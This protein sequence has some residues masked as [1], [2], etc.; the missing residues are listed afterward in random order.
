MSRAWNS[1]MSDKEVSDLA[2][3]ERNM[4]VL[5][6]ANYTNKV[7]SDWLQYEKSRNEDISQE[8]RKGP[9]S[10]WYVDDREEMKGWSRVISVHEGKFTVHVPDDFV[11]GSLPQ[12]PAN[13]NGHSTEEKW[14]MVDK[15]CGI[16]R[17]FEAESK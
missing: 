5:Y 13:W 11:M 4:A 6:M 8:L 2:Y 3:Y 10:G 14:K 1:S 12:I 7:W 9:P 16:A 15:Y 17:R